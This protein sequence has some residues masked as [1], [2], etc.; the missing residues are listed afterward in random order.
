MEKRR[1]QTPIAPI[2]AQFSCNRS[3]YNRDLVSTSGYVL[4]ALTAIIVGVIILMSNYIDED[5]M[6]IY[7]FL[8]EDFSHTVSS[9]LVYPAVVYYCKPDLRHYVVNDLLKEMFS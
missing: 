8:L 4:L 2:A 1:N 9:L 7:L 6:K 3:R 5:G